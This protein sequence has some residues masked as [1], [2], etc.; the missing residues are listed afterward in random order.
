MQDIED[1]NGNDGKKV[2]Q[3]P[4]Y[5]VHFCLPYDRNDHNNNNN[6]NATGSPFIRTTTSSRRRIYHGV[7]TL[8]RRDTIINAANPITSFKTI[9]WDNEGRLLICEI[10]HLHLVFMNV[11]ALNGTTYPYRDPI[12]GMVMG[13]RHERKRA[14]HSLLAGEVRR[15][16]HPHHP[17]HD[18]DN[19]GD[20]DDDNGDDGS[21]Q[22]ITIP[23]KSGPGSGSRSGGGW[24]VII[25]GDMNISRTPLDS[26]PALRMGEE[27]VRSR[28]DF[29]TKFLSSPSPSSPSSSSSSAVIETGSWLGMLDTFRH[30][31]PT[32][33]KYT[34]RPTHH[35]SWNISG[36]RVDMILVTR[37]LEGSVK[38]A[39]M[40]DDDE[41][42][43]G[44]RGS[45]DHVP[46]FLEL[47]LDLDLDLEG[48]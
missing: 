44:E 32:L 3:G 9:P 4:Q 13:T 14:F 33:A 20:D 40:L 39:D 10:P 5:D 43:E 1:D 16:H 30:L 7:C 48:G 19:D 27:H 34:Y 26:H 6:D 31:H 24:Q 21:G 45:S 38:M 37:G 12:T 23:H 25:A 46:L 22:K 35:Q 28:A 8:A 11:Y 17:H 36:D 2:D 15:Y 18:H 47:D 42:K 41:G 29:E